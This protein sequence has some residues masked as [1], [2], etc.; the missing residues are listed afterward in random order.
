MSGEK[1]VNSVEFKCASLEILED[2][3]TVIYLDAP[4]NWIK[5]QKA[6]IGGVIEYYL[7]G[8]A[9]IYGYEIE[10][11]EFWSID[12]VFWLRRQNELNRFCN[13]DLEW[14]EREYGLIRTLWR[15]LRK[16]S[17]ETFQKGKKIWLRKRAVKDFRMDIYHLCNLIIYR[18]V[19]REK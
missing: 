18:G 5:S 15:W 2:G 13:H 6:L 4:Y 10:Y 3:K 11:E 7:D 16:K 17:P 12:D 8:T 9:S 14:V 19:N 1:L